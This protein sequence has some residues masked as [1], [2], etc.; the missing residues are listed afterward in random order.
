MTPEEK[1]VVTTM[2]SLIKEAPTPPPSGEG[3][4]KGGEK[5]ITSVG[6]EEFVGLTRMPGV[7]VTPNINI[8][9][10][11]IGGGCCVHLSIEYMPIPGAGGPASGKPDQMSVVYAEVL[12]SESTL[13]GW[14]K[15]VDSGY[16][17]KECIITTNPGAI[18]TVGA[19]NAIARVRWCEVFSC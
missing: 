18:L 14:A 13:L 6:G 8:G 19:V 2:R 11:V 7:I 3:E 1:R 4:K 17:I 12:D 15:V 9:K 16:H 5:L 10:A